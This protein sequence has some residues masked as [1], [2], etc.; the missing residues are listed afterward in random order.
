[1][2]GNK[3]NLYRLF[4]ENKNKK[5]ICQLVSEHFSGFT[6]YEAIGYWRGKQEKTLVIEIVSISSAD[7]FKLRK[8][9]ESIKGYNKQECVLVQTTK[10]DCKYI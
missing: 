9:C 5:W 6:M 10:V 4:T 8:I 1:M 2:K 7:N 3:M